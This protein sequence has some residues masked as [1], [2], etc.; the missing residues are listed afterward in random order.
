MLQVYADG[1]LAL[2]RFAL[3]AARFGVGIDGGGMGMGVFIHAIVGNAGAIVG[4]RG[5][6]GWLLVVVGLAELWWLLVLLLLLLLLLVV[7]YM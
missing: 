1:E 4:W 6:V 7:L 3:A 5:L 2:A